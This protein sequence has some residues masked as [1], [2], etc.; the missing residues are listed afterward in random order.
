VLKPGLATVM[1]FTTDFDS[2]LVMD[3]VFDNAKPSYVGSR[4]WFKSIR[5]NGESI[6]VRDLV[7][8]LMASGFQHHYPVAYGDLAAASLELAA[9]LGMQSIRRQPYAPYLT[10]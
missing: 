6:S 7:Q 5:L 10:P 1:G 9:W 4:G 8:T 3:G 2:M